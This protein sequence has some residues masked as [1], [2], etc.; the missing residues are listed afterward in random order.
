MLW[1][2]KNPWGLK[3]GFP[4]KSEKI[5][6]AEWKDLQVRPARQTQKE[7][8]FLREARGWGTRL[9]TGKAPGRAELCNVAAP[10][11]CGTNR[12]TWDEGFNFLALSLKLWGKKNHI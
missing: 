9:G 5:C 6:K 8:S 3:V 10:G 12:H 4:K 7:G 1:G 2:E 11:A